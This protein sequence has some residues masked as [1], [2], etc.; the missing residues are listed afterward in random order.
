ML[1]DIS[2]QVMAAN[3]SFHRK[4]FEMTM[5]NGFD[6]YLMRLQTDGRCRARIDNE[7]SLIESG[8]LLIFSP[9]QPYELRI[10]EEMNPQGES[11][12][13]S[14][15]YHIFFK[16]PWVDSWWQSRRR[17]TRVRIPLD[18][19]HIGLFRQVIMEQ[20]R[21]SNPCPE[22]SDYTVRVLC[23]EVDRLLSEQPSTTPKLY[24]A[25]RMKNYIEENASSMFKLEDVAA[26]VDISVSR[27]VHLF[28]EAFGTTIMQYT[29][30]VRI[31]MARERIIFSG[32][33][34]E[35]VAETSGFANYTYFHRV[36]RSRF[37]I[38]PKQ[39]RMASRTSM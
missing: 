7:L 4:P 12:V 25:H 9:G 6:T 18:E 15:D 36:F 10:D 5:L 21:L 19:R 24:L 3:F 31:D 27:A 28:K 23:L 1:E 38:S 14:G 20:R 32:M 2:T 29:L 13:E 16:G 33:S 34:L 26:H 11:I 8:D 39:F 17:P 37:G 22:I 35:D 30:D